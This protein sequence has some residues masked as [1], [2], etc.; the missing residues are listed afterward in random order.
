M[1][2]PIVGRPTSA[3]AQHEGS[4]LS[5]HWPASAPAVSRRLL[6]GAA[7]CPRQAADR[8]RRPGGRPV[9]RLG[10]PDNADLADPIAAWR[11]VRRSSAP[12]PLRRRGPGPG[13]TSVPVRPAPA[14]TRHADPGQDPPPPPSRLDPLVDL[15]V[16]RPIVPAAF[17]KL[18]A[19]A[20]LA[21][22]LLPAPH[23]GAQSGGGD[24]SNL[25]WWQRGS[26]PRR[27]ATGSLAV[28]PRRAGCPA[29]PA[30]PGPPPRPSAAVPE[31][32]GRG[33]AG[34]VPS[35]ARAGTGTPARPAAPAE[36]PALP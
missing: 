17:R 16:T 11:P 2:T 22:P 10:E 18:D 15:I 3:A 24:P 35:A 12:A 27:R 19:I 9:S 28:S 5:P 21:G 30:R 25:G 1:D 23:A 36:C 14:A 31:R 8:R 26:R 32:H 6:T 13:P 20:V 29:G 34:R 4:R 7:G 33:P